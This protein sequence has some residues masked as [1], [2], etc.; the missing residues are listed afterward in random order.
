MSSC[1]F[2]IAP[3]TGVY[4]GNALGLSVPVKPPFSQLRGAGA[5]VGVGVGV[6]G[7]ECDDATV[8]V[9]AYEALRIPGF[10][11][12]PMD[13]TAGAAYGT[14]RVIRSCD[15]F[16]IGVATCSDTGKVCG[17]LLRLL[18]SDASDSHV[19][20][21]R[22][23]QTF[24][25]GSVYTLTLPRAL[26]LRHGKS[27]VTIV[28]EGYYE[29]SVYPAVA[30]VRLQEGDDDAELSSE[31]D[32]ECTGDGEIESEYESEYESEHE[33]NATGTASGSTWAAHSS[34]RRR[35]WL[36]RPAP[37]YYDVIRTPS[38]GS[39]V[40]VCGTSNGTAAVFLVDDLHGLV[41]KV[42]RL[43]VR[44]SLA[45]CLVLSACKKMLVVGVQ[46]PDTSLMWALS[47]DTMQELYSL[48]TCAFN[49]RTTKRLRLPHEAASVDVL[50][51][52]ASPCGSFYALA[53][54]WFPCRKSGGK[55]MQQPVSAVAVYRFTADTA[56]DIGFGMGGISL[57]FDAHGVESRPCDAVLHKDSL[58][59]VGNVYFGESL[60]RHRD[61]E[62]DTDSSV[63][64]IYLNACLPFLSVDVSSPPSPFLL[65]FRRSSLPCAI[66]LGLDGCAE[67]HFSNTVCLNPA[68]SGSAI[69]VFGDVWF[70]L[71]RP[72]QAAGLLA[73]DIAL[74]QPPRI[75]NA[76]HIRVP[77]IDYGGC[78][79]PITVDKR[80][81]ATALQVAGPVIVGC[82]PV[83]CA[84]IFPG[85][86]A[87]DATCQAFI[88]FDGISW[89]RFKM[90]DERVKS[91]K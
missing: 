60:R 36:R 76:Q 53:T 19:V 49:D 57:W 81:K 38:D 23:Q 62:C 20:V 16:A 28:G 11:A 75:I 18:A 65:Q 46:A 74:Q 78:C 69:T 32:G 25:G 33:D 79:E 10:V 90:N 17:F 12:R 59:V 56:P 44:G 73:V 72:S 41:K 87:F 82:P 80:C 3:A 67:G 83:D 52:F 2:S 14:M 84:S 77:I 51:L 88:G 5:G 48:T 91:F 70:H 21:T 35:G 64:T 89:K 8:R 4:R 66:F 45:T 6:C 47:A 30:H 85:A 55:G 13:G 39:A 22:L 42:G 68:S 86:I 63:A 1:A 58:Y 27:V 29:G 43:R 37:E 26:V 15:G 50:R 71:G 24:D 31:S 54:A 34:D 61:R 7:G 40:Y 9:R